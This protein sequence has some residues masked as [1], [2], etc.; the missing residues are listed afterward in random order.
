MGLAEGVTIAPPAERRNDARYGCCQ[1]HIDWLV[2]LSWPCCLMYIYY[3]GKEQKD[4]LCSPEHAAK[5]HNACYVEM[6]SIERSE[7]NLELS[8]L[9][10]IS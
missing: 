6:A 5:G 3:H 2:A 8:L 1:V 7:F 4:E 9:V 10:I